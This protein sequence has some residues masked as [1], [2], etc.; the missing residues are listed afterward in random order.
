MSLVF[1]RG[2]GKQIHETAPACPGCGAPQP[3]GRQAAGTR[4]PLALTALVLAWT[5]AF[6]IGGLLLAGAVVGALNPERAQEAGARVGE[7]IGAPLLLVALVAA[8][9]LTVAGRLPGTRRT[10]ARP[11]P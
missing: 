4:N 6:W 7:L 3:T 1:C 10:A 8:I 11:T 9:G 2:C 5:A